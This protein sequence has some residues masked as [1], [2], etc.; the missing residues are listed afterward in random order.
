[1]LVAGYRH[2]QSRVARAPCI[3]ARFLQAPF[4]RL[5]SQVVIWATC[6]CASHGPD[7]LV[8]TSIWQTCDVLDE[9]GEDSEVLRLDLQDVP[10]R[11]NGDVWE[12]EGHDEATAALDPTIAGAALGQFLTVSWKR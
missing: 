7:A 10:V 6:R 3:H 2:S 8:P 5:H 12:E 9:G 11:V 4:G 1:M